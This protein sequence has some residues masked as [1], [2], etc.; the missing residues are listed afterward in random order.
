MTAKLPF[1]DAYVHYIDHS[2]K[3]LVYE[4]LLP[5]AR[6]PN[7]GPG[8]ERLKKKSWLVDEFLRDARSSNIVASVHSEAWAGRVHDPVSETSWLQSEARRTGYPQAVVAFAN[9]LA[10]N[11]QDVL[12]RH[13]RHANLRAVRHFSPGDFLSDPAFHARFA[14]LRAFGLSYELSARPRTMQAAYD[15]AKRFPDVPMALVHCGFPW[16]LSME[17]ALAWRRGMQQL[18]RAQ[19]VVCKISGL[20]VGDHHWT[21]A[22]LRPWVLHCIE[23]FGTK[24]VMFGSHW[25]VDTLYTSYETLIDAFREIIK[26]FSLDEQKDLLAGNCLRFYRIAA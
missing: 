20:P 22:S 14:L 4:W 8:L 1:A 9:L 23:A 13:S 19:N 26:D 15:F 12:E 17:N 6:D 7:I 3:D 18:A 25:P 2:R 21:V 10:P 11:A 16:Y 5:E 24:R